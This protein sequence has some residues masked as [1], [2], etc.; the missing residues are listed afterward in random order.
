MADP[1]CYTGSLTHAVLVVGYDLT[2]LQPYWLIRNSWGPDWCSD[3]FMRLAIEGGDGV[4]GINVLPA[5][6]PIPA[7]M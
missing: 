2:A 6:Y 7:R 4:C 1:D 3:G 5:Y